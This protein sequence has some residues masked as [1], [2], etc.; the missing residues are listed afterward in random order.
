MNLKQKHTILEQLFLESKYDSIVEYWENNSETLDFFNKDKSD[1]IAEILS[2]SFIETGRIEQALSYI[3]N[4]LQFRLTKLDSVNDEYFIDDVTTFYK[5]KIEAYEKLGKLFHEYD[6][7]N[8]C[9]TYR[10]DE[11]VIELKNE[12]ENDLINKLEIFNRV[13]LVL[14]VILS[15]LSFFNIDLFEHKYFDVLSFFLLGWV[16][17]TMVFSKWVR[18]LFL[19]FVRYVLDRIKLT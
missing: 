17:I 14:V 1:E 7:V 4:Y 5:L 18:V 16:V 12:I 6:S 9:L 11:K 13:V 2:V 19:N 3:D 15:L 8:K 10:C